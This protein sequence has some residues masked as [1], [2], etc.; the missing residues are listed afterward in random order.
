MEKRDHEILND[1]LRNFFDMLAPKWNEIVFPAHA[2][3]L[4]ALIRHLEIGSGD[5]IL[6]V[7]TGTGVLLPML[8]PPNTTGRHVAAV[9][10]AFEMLREAQQRPGIEHDNVLLIQADAHRMPFAAE[11]FDWILCNS[12]FPHFHDQAACVQHLAAL[13]KPCGG[14]MV[15]HSQSRTAINEL[16]R[17]KGGLI[18]G[19]E[20]PE[21][22]EMEDI[23]AGAGL[24]IQTHEDTPEYYFL[25]AR[26]G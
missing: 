5:T 7:G 20:L 23:F 25:V 4:A 12:V 19:H 9:D 24:H 21:R 2:E 18:G 22:K 26:K 14:F 8:V 17:A 16:H 10:I 13:L 15:C 6:D 3:Q 11:T 1:R